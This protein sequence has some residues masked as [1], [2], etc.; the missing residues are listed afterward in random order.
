MTSFSPSP[1]LR[2]TLESAL[3]ILLPSTAEQQKIADC[4][5]ALDTLIGAQAKEIAALKDHKKG[6]MQQ[7]FPN[8]NLCRA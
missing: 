1:K 5:N 7:L 3:E 8:P 6:M 4:L 2:C